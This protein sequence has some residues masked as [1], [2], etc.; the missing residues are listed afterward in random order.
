MREYYSIDENGFPLDNFITS[1]EEA[2][3]K[4]LVPSWS[5]QDGY[6]KVWQVPRYDRE[7]GAWVEAKDDPDVPAPAPVPDEE[8][9]PSEVDVL[10]AENDELNRRLEVTEAALLSLMDFI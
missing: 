7:I 9:T 2:A 10:K 8:L 1:D 4:G 5:E 3:E 6:E